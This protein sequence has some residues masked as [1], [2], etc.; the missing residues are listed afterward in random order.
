MTDTLPS[1]AERERKSHLWA[2]DPDDWYVEPRWCDDALFAAVEFE[3]AI[4]DPCC[5]LGRVLDAAKAAGYDTIGADLWDRG[6]GDRHFFAQRD[7]FSD[8]SS[9]SNVVCN[10][11]YKFSD[12]F[13]SH[14]VERSRGKTAVLLRVQWANAGARSRWLEALPLRHVLMLSPRPSMPPG[15]VVVAGERVGGGRED[16]AWFVFERGYAG[17][18]EFGWARRGGK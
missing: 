6:L 13:V 4:V 2:C 3:G 5:G 10:P 18:P 11:P 16:Y 15:A 12:R 17:R 9:L 14:A 8:N 1:G 7:F